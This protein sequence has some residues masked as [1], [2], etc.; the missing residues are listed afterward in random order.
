MSK[1]NMYI[2]DVSVEAVFN[3]LGGVEGARQFLCGNVVIT[4]V[5]HT[6]DLGKQPRLPFDRAEA[7]KHEGEGIVEIEQRSD[8]N[9]YLG[10]KKVELFLSERQKGDKTIIGHELRKELASEPMLNAKV[11][12]YLLANT[13]LIPKE[14]KVDK[15]GPRYIFFWGTICHYCLDLV[16]VRY[17]YFRRGEWTWRCA[18]LGD[19]WGVSFPVAR[20]AS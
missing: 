17:L 12:D 8:Y 3:R 5:R 15:F 14:W 2:E 7:A 11:L 16:Y 4:P 13:H 19:I 6:I 1:Y 18:W 20:L 10:D 9:L